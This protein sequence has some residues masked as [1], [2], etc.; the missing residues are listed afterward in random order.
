MHFGA[1]LRG[2]AVPRIPTPGA[3]RH[4][5]AAVGDPDFLGLTPEPL[6]E[7]TLRPTPVRSP[8][9]HLE[10]PDPRPARFRP[11]LGTT[12]LGPHAPGAPQVLF[13]VHHLN[14]GGILPLT[15]LGLAWA[16]IYTQVPSS[17]RPIQTPLSPSAARAALPCASLDNESTFS[18]HADPPRARGQSRNL[19]VTILIHALWNSRVFLGSF[20]TLFVGL[21]AL[22]FL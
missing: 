6:T 13:A 16:I 18:F 1:H 8:T 19:L 5:A 14:I 11:D 21:P 17:A 7:P 10:R 2:G 12:P 15:V 20:N 22:P 3:G 4:D 9:L